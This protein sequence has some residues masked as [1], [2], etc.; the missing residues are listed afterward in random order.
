MLWPSPVVVNDPFHAALVCPRLDK[1]NQGIVVAL[2]VWKVGAELDCCYGYAFWETEVLGRGV[3]AE[4]IGLVGR[5]SGRCSCGGG[6][7]HYA[8]TF[9]NYTSAKVKQFE[10]SRG[11][12][13]AIVTENGPGVRQF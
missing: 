13:Y 4:Y 2:C 10:L 8:S 6:C 5:R 7:S 9:G 3:S 11:Y 1:A 12:F